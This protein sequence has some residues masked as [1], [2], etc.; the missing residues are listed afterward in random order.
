MYLQ[1]FNNGLLYITYKR[2]TRLLF[3]ISIL[4]PILR[5][6]KLNSWSLNDICGDFG[7][8]NRE[9]RTANLWLIVA[10][11]NAGHHCC[12]ITDHGP[13]K[14]LNYNDEGLKLRDARLTKQYLVL[15]VSHYHVAPLGALTVFLRL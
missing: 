12:N 2:F 3:T 8:V 4:I 6:R 1:F 13:Q 15:F 14:Q 10:E 11:A 9:P 7:S 5:K